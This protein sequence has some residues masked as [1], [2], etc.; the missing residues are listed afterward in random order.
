MTT[1][2]MSRGGDKATQERRGGR[3]RVLDEEIRQERALGRRL[4]S[5]K[6]ADGAE[7]W[8]NRVA[9]R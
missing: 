8:P 2:H 6:R 1:K 5:E 9:Q 3:W 4:P 7:G